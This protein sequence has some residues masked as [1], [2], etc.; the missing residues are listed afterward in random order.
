M[1]AVP[2]PL[3]GCSNVCVALHSGHAQ[4]MA[5]AGLEQGLQALPLPPR[6]RAQARG[7]RAAAALLSDASREVEASA[8][9]HTLLSL[10]MQSGEAPGTG[11]RVLSVS[12]HPPASVR[13][14]GSGSV[15]PA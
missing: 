3:E 5:V 14:S 2:S 1:A 4:L 8:L 11:R 13:R 15:C 12:A 6:L 7:V 10:A 9:L